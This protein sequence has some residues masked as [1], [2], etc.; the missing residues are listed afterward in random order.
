M[1]E[2]R[3]QPPK[4][5]RSSRAAVGLLAFA[6]LG[7][8]GIGLLV[9]VDGLRRDGPGAEAFAYQ[10]ASSGPLPKLWQLPGFAFTDHRS[11]PV[12]RDSLRGQP[13]IA[14]FIFTQ[15]TSAC[16]MLTSRMVRIQRRLAG[17]AVRFVSFS[18]DPAHDDVATLAGYAERWNPREA[19]WSLLA[20]DAQKLAELLAAFRVTA[21][22]TGDPD[23]PILHTSMFFLVDADSTVRGVYATDDRA[24]LE[25][26]VRDASR[27]GAPP[28]AVGG[29][30]PLTYASLGCPGCHENPKVA[31]ALI[32]LSGA[33]RMLETGKHVAVDRAYLR[34]SLLEPASEL[35]HGYLPLMPSYRD[36]LG[37]AELERLVDELL[38]RTGDAAGDSEPVEVVSDPVCH[39]RVRVQADTPSASH[40]GRT[41]HFCSLACRDAFVA[42]P[43]RYPLSERATAP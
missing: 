1:L 22:G 15:C 34:R 9:V 3:A 35:V 38:A 11:A 30:A 40:G 7:S 16:P 43:A 23:N 14:D 24:A 17:Q 32:N 19:R 27:L 6:V 8:L 41:V 21:A 28:A 29:P 39:M 37:E 4:A 42:S 5:D 13:F 31:P 26:L 12:S 10:P 36:E 33:K 20:T 2:P 25:R 18:V